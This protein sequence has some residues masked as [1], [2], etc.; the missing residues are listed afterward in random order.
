MTTEFSASLDE[1]S[2]AKAAHYVRALRRAILSYWN[3]TIEGKEAALI[4]AA[5]ASII[6]NVLD[7]S[8]FGATQGEP[9]N[10]HRVGDRL[11]KVVVGL[12]LV[13][14]CEVHAPV[15]YPDLLVERR[16]IGVPLNNGAQAMRQVWHWAEYHD[17]PAGYVDVATTASDAQK[18]ARGEAQHG[19]REAVQ[20]RSVIETLF[21]AERFFLN[22]EPRL[23]PHQADA[24]TYSF[25]EVQLPDGMGLYRPLEG[26]VGSVSL[27]DMA[28]RWYERTEVLQ[29]PADEYFEKLRKSLVK[30]TPASERAVTHRILDRGRCIGYT[31]ISGNGVARLTWVER[32][33]QIG[34]DIKN[35]AVYT[36]EHDDGKTPVVATDNLKLS[37]DVGSIDLLASLPEAEDALGLGRLR[38][39]ESYPDLYV[40]MRT[41]SSP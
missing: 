3:S 26:S 17:L 6:V 24:L 9:Y 19:Y 21:D 10:A 25:A 11:G 40:E 27:P 4:E 5:M 36:L 8:V 41:F 34:R 31:G 22:L 13:R 16:M 15:I 39:S 20:G 18:R 7:E 29:T 1:A 23:R 14:N 32:S 30:D 28:T 38:F 2:F 12:E 37:A 35:G 33:A